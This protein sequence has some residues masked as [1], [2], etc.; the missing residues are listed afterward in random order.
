MKTVDAPEPAGCC[1]DRKPKNKMIA[2]A[3]RTSLRNLRVEFIVASMDPRQSHAKLMKVGGTRY[4]NTFGVPTRLGVVATVRLHDPISRD[5][6]A[7]I[8]HF[9]RARPAKIRYI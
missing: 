1:N 8:I 4:F 9:S 2:P 3:A 7:A 6:Q 5:P